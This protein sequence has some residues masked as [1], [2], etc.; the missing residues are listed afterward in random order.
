MKHGMEQCKTDPCVFRKIR[1]GKLVMILAVHV[2]DIAVAGVPDEI[3][4][5]EKVLN[6]DFSTANLGL[7]NLFTG[8]VV[9][10]DVEHGFVTISQTPF[11][12]T[13][14]KRFDVTKTFEHPAVVGADL[15]A[16]KEGESGGPWPYREAVGSLM[17]LVTMTRPDIANAVR[18]VARHSHNPTERHWKAVLRIIGYLLG[19]KDLGITFQRGF[20]FDLDFLRILTLLRRRM[21]DV[22]FRGSRFVFVV[23][24]Y[25]GRVIR[26]E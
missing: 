9:E 4:K 20:G 17:W 5:L 7:L 10:Q 2:D 16:R 1:D 21:T 14:A 6:E 13:L 23:Q 26:R 3:E 24:S 18:A 22:L 8:C 19:S 25:L 11:I 12:E 15:D